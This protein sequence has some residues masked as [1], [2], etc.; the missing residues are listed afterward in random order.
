MRCRLTTAQEVD[1]RSTGGL[2]VV[3]SIA[4]SDS[5][6]RQLIGA[7]AN[8]PVSHVNADFSYKPFGFV[9]LVVRA[10]KLYSYIIPM[11]SRK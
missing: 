11:D 7:L 4:F 9:I 2:P 8:H 1:G 5:M 3:G 10:S 6:E